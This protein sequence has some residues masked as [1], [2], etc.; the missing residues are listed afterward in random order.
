[1]WCAEMNQTKLKDLI[2]TGHVGKMVLFRVKESKPTAWEVWAYDWPDSGAYHV[3][4]YDN[5]M[6]SDKT[7]EPVTFETLDSA[8]AEVRSFGYSGGIEI[9]G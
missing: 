5:R 2:A 8:H 9:D 1:M 7:S 3:K 4:S 6:L